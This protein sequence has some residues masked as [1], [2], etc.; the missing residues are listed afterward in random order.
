MPKFN[1][2]RA[3]V[4]AG[5]AGALAFSG[6]AVAFATEG[7]QGSQ[8]DY[9]LAAVSDAESEVINVVFKQIDPATGE[10]DGELSQL[11]FLKDESLGTIVGFVSHKDYEG[12]DFVGW[13]DSRNG[14]ILTTTVIAGQLASNDVTFTTVYEKKGSTEQPTLTEVSV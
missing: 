2:R 8:A 11:G 13:K 12:Y 9:Q 10:Q 14:N 4:S 7:V 5:L 3:V 6:T 1:V